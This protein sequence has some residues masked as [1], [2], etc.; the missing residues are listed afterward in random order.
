VVLEVRHDLDDA[1]LG[2]V[3]ERLDE[4]R[5]PSGS[6]TF[7]TPVSYARICWVRSA[8]VADSSLGNANG[9]SHAAVNMDCTP[10]STDAIAS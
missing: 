5:A 4:V 6:A 1:G 3:G 2:G 9:S 10:P 8:S 7:A